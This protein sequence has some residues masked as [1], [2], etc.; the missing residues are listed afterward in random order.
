MGHPETVEAESAG[1]LLVV[2]HNSFF[3]TGRLKQLHDVVVIVLPG[4]VQSGLSHFI[5]GVN[6][7]SGS[8]QRPDVAYEA[9]RSRHHQSS[10]ALI[11]L[12]IHLG[13]RLQQCV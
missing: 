2:G 11:I 6:I 3:C 4:I 10:L 8:N 1:P 12:V 7:C 13:S 9:R 5:S